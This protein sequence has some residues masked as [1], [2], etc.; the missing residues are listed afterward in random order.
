LRTLIKRC[1][2]VVSL[3]LNLF[4]GLVQADSLEQLGTDA[5]KWR[6]ET[7]A[8]SGD[9]IPRIAR[10]AGWLPDW[11]GP[12]ISARYRQLALYED[13]WRRLAGTADSPQLITDYRL[14]GSLLAR[15]RWE[16]DH[17]AAW[18]RQP[19]F[20]ISQ[21]LTPVF[22]ALLPPPPLN[23][24]RTAH[25]QALLQQVPI[26]LAAA[27]DNLSDRRGPFV[28]VA[29]EQ[30]KRVPDSLRG[31]YRGLAAY[32][33]AP[34]YA[35]MKADVDRALE[36]F[37][38]FGEF[39]EADRGSLNQEIS[40][41]RESY[42]FF[43]SEVALYPFTAEQLT[44]MGAQEWQ[45]SAAFEV[46]EANRNRR[47]ENLAIAPSLDAVIARL[48][49][50][51]LGVRQF[52]QQQRL[53]T[54]PDGVGHY[55][56]R[57]FPEYLKPIAWLGRTLDLTDQHRLGSNATVYLPEP[58]PDLGF[59]N[60]SIAR[61]PRP[62]LV[63]E[64]VPGHYLQL[65]LSWMHPNPLRRH[66]Y[67]S[68]ANEGT[69]FYAEEMMLQAGYF[70]DSPKTRELIY[71]FARFRALRVE[72]DV[73]L[74]GGEFTIDEAARYLEDKMDLDRATAVQEAIFFAATPG[75]AISY[76][77]GKLQTLAFLSAAR[78]QLGDRFDLLQLHD[79]LWR[80]GNVPIALQQA[81]FLALNKP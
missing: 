47:E 30:L 17:V 56:A 67:D 75:Q 10:P 33:P 9:D 73:K 44:I 61:D 80:N 70:D 16:L 22:E 3:T 81:E 28:D 79:Y 19:H 20:Y 46:M 38:Q 74:A 39:L 11:S 48:S 36:A 54:I 78:A 52:M 6:S 8:A 37:V 12:A 43:L 59:F 15:V 2:F 51:E 29:L 76:Q 57:A 4:A 32:L 35:Q 5:W 25:L 69:G 34:E 50:E 53:L 14:L 26:T 77:I 40:V 66:Y 42:Q 18:Q 27:Q 55:Q 62:I 64:G 21:A 41:G 65:V 58:S 7:Q 1:L 72:V 45:R 49:R 71:T 24:R 63:H 68:G 23:S 13:R 31:M 60:L